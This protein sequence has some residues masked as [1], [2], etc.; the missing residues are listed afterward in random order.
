MSELRH[1]TTGVSLR[2]VLIGAV[3]TAAISVISPWGALLVKGSELTSNA[4]PIIAVLFLFALVAVVMPVLK[5]LTPR[6]GLSR[7]E[8]I[9]VFIMM[10]AGSVVPTKG[11]AG[12]FLSVVTGPIYYATP[13]N[14]WDSLFLPYIHEWL[15]PTDRQAVRF[16]Y[17]GLPQGMDIPWSAWLIPF[18]AWAVFLLAFYWTLFCTGV[19]LRGQWLD[20]ERLMFPLTR[21]P[22]AMVE[23][24]DDLHRK[25]GALFK[26]PLMWLGFA[27]PLILHSWNSLHSYSEIFPQLPLRGSLTLLHGEVGVP[28]NL[29]FPVIGLG[30]LMQLNVTFS[31][32]FFYMLTVLQRWVFARIG[33]QIGG[34]DVWNSG[35]TPTTIMH[36]Q[37]GAMLVLCL[38]VLWTA[39]RHLKEFFRRAWQ[40]DE[41]LEIETL[42]PRAAV[43]GL[44]VG[45]ALMVCWLVVT[46]L[47]F[48]VALLLVL[49]A[50]LVFIGLAR[51]VGEAGMPSCQ[52]PMVPQAFIM[53]GFGPETLGMRNLTGLGFST[54]WMGETSANMMNAVI[55]ALKLIQSQNRSDR[56]LVWAFALAILIALAGSILTTMHLAYKYGGINLEYWYFFGAPHWPFDYASS[57]ALN[58]EKS[59][60]PRLTFTAIGG[61]IMAF[62]LY[63]RHHFLWWP[64]HPIGFPIAATFPVHNYNW[65]ALFLAWLLKGAIMHYGGVG[66]YRKLLPFFLGL[67]LGHFSTATLWVFIDGINGVQGNVIFFY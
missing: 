56:R 26:N 27:I 67:I 18:A 52:T 50:L 22:L 9:V 53:R 7:A 31:I 5:A 47:S 6:L 33:L 42:S 12:S 57:V 4:I 41:R 15:A 23:G 21:I 51:I 49:G 38:F 3:L 55:H 16:L 25:L 66:L 46:G 1:R 32:W 10:L 62:L 39:R 28:I 59:F 43:V 19:L 45:V 34:T 36:E 24:A 8:L 11:L 44:V 40:K 2:A 54:T 65:F 35:T 17:E 64:L 14:N 48:Y 13:E 30:Y 20:N 29:N 37:A 61:G 60:M 63:M 58:P